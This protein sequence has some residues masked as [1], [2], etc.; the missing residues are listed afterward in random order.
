MWTTQGPQDIGR[1]RR[2]RNSPAPPDPRPR[3]RG[4]RQARVRLP[5]PGRPA[6]R[7]S[8]PRCQPARQRAQPFAA[9]D[10]GRGPGEAHGHDRGP[11]RRAGGPA[12]IDVALLREHAG[13]LAGLLARGAPAGDVD[14]ALE[15]ARA[16]G[17][18]PVAL[19]Q[20]VREGA[21][22]WE[23]RER[24]M[25]DLELYRLGLGLIG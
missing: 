24:T 18:N 8:G 14:L 12:V 9:R 16:A 6:R 23:E 5:L 10:R 15:A 13:R 19:S 3:Q 2:I 25:V 1:P 22:D 20:A 4:R 21:L 11:A 17:L 7:H